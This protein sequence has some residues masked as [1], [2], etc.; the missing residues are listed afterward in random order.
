LNIHLVV[1]GDKW[2]GEPGEKKDDNFGAKSGLRPLVVERDVL[3]GPDIRDKLR[4]V[5][6]A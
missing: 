6:R 2:Y 5:I 1:R 3:V 4:L